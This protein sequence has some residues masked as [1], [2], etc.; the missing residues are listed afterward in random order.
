VSQ[1]TSIGTITTGLAAYQTFANANAATQATSINA[2]TANLLSFQTYANLTFGTGNYGNA[3]VFGYLNSYNGNLYAASLAST[4]LV[5][6]RGN[7]A[8]TS[9]IARNVY[10]NSYAPSSTQGN[11]GDIWYQTF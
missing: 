5:Y 11:I 3:N 6:S 1:S 7:V 2:I 10:V 4:G 8:M 9:N